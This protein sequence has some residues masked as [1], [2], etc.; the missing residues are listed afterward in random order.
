MKLNLWE[1]ISE[2][3][4][5]TTQNQQEKLIN[6]LESNQ[7]YQNQQENFINNLQSNQKYQN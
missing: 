2:E 4:G 3:D 7:K 1:S 5:E 6:N